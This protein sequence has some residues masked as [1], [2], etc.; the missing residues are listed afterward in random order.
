MWS[1][2]TLANSYMLDR[3]LTCQLDERNEHGGH[4]EEEIKRK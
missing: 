4:N 1:T 3:T 2:D